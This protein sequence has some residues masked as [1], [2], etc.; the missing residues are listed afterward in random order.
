MARRSKKTKA[1]HTAL[2]ESQ[3][4]ALLTKLRACETLRPEEYEALLGVTQTWAHLSEVAASKT[5]SIREVRRILGINPFR[6]S[7]TKGH[8]EQKQEKTPEQEGIDQ[9]SSTKEQEVDNKVVCLESR[10]SRDPHGRRK[11]SAFENLVEKSHHHTILSSGCECPDCARGKLYK[12]RPN[13]FTTVSGRSPLV[14]TRHTQ[15]ALQCNLCKAVYKAPM[16]QECVDDGV[17]GLVMYSYSAV[18]ITSIYRFF[19]GMPMHRQETLQKALGVAV[20]D[21]SIWDMCEKLA[22]HLRPIRRYLMQQSKDAMVFHGDDTG[23]TVLET[24]SKVK[25][26]RQTGQT[27]LRTGCH[28]TCIIAKLQEGHQ[29]LLF[30]TGIHHTGEVMD[31]LVQERSDGLAPPLFMCDGLSS[32]TVSQAVVLYGGCNA[33][34]VRRFKDLAERYGEHARYVLERY[35]QIYE[36]EAHCVEAQLGPEER[37]DHHRSNSRELLREITEYGEDHFERQ[38]FEPN[39]DLGRAFEYVINQERRLSAFCRHPHA[40]LDNN[41]CER[42]LRIFVRLR[43]TSH[44]F[45]NGVGSLVADTVLSVGATAM[46]AGVNLFDYFVAVQR[47]AEDVHL[48][49]EHWVPWRYRER[50]RALTG[51]SPPITGPPV[52]S[53]AET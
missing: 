45:R 52:M 18:A 27:T 17:S 11:A 25:K 53:F 30:F 10:K 1:A 34:A 41:W 23:A 26:N 32:N 29:A 4:D 13:T 46:H 22:N 3:V 40:P 14:A 2:S 50:I 24:R 37:R 15:E 31:R 12:Y 6:E 36:N 19:A 9:S 48:H 33:H 42:T 39:S 47:H 20:P 49:P 38:S 16:P 21:S 5:G 7:Q 43:E 44:F 35:R 51:T 28:T 8:A